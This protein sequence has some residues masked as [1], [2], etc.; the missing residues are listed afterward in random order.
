MARL[1]AP[2]P[3]GG[4]HGEQC[5]SLEWRHYGV[6]G[7]HSSVPLGMA[8]RVKA[9]LALISVNDPVNVYAGEFEVRPP[10]APTTRPKFGEMSLVSK[11]LATFKDLSVRFPIE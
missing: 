8:A 4:L 9:I 2:W 10:R 1:I 6:H 7:L 3:R 11:P 5:T